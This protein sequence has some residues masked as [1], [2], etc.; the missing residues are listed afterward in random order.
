MT[1]ASRLFTK[2]AGKLDNRFRN[3]HPGDVLHYDFGIGE[4]LD[5]ED[6]AAETGIAISKIKSVVRCKAGIDA[7]M[8]LRLGRYFQLP[9]GFFLR[10]QNDYDLEAVHNEADADLIQ[11]EPRWH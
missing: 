9:D 7:D 8:D 4:E 5:P 3:V 2:A 6:L 11:I 10:M 1:L